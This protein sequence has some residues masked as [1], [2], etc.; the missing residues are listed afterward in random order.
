M[1]LVA[2]NLQPTGEETH[3]SASVEL[4]GARYTLTA[5]TNAIDEAWYLDIESADGAA[6]VRG[7]GLAV[8]MDLLFPYRYLDLPPGPL[9]VHDQ[10]LEGSDPDLAAFADGRAAIFYLEVTS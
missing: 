2:I 9:F 8:G 1:S 6:V 4:D 7:L 5:Y 10:G 3:H